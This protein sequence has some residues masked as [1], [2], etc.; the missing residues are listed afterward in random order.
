MGL[1]VI[2]ER[3]SWTMPQERYNADWVEQRGFGIAIR[4]IRRDIVEAVA[5][6]VDPIRRACFVERVSAYRNQAV[7]EIPQILDRIL[8]A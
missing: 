8:S 7:F 5:A 3:N 4:S 6:M 2:I 1:P